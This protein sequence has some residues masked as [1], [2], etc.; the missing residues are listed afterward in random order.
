MA[1]LLPPLLLT[2]GPAAGKTVTARFLA[3]TTPRTAYLDVDDI[4]QLVK[5]G[6]A[7]P[8]DGTEGKAQHVLG[9]RNAAALARN[10]AGAGFNVTITDVVDTFTLA[11]YRRLLP[12]VFVVRLAISL[13]AA[14]LRAR[15]RDVH[16]TDAEFDMLHA[17][18][19]AALE[20]DEELDVTHL[21]QARQA[22][23]VGALWTR[24]WR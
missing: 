4:R 19:L 10:F 6:G 8:W 1:P 22:Q 12:D 24:R 15:T 21:D 2:G 16:L 14:W 13:E 20:V 9:V 17:Q 7:A 5:N 3:E 11:E 23:S 18:Q